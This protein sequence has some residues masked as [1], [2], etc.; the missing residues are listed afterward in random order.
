MVTSKPNHRWY[1]LTPDRFFV[2]LLVVQV[3]LFLSDRF[4]WFTFNEHKGWTVLIAVGVVCCA[5]L[6]M[7]MWGI[8]CLCLRWRF[9]FSFQSL[10]LFLVVVSVPL[11]WFAW[12]M[13]KARQQREGSVKSS[14][15]DMTEEDR[16]TIT[17]TITADEGRNP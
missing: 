17:A 13:Q 14:M 8:I 15:K 5:V 1:H 9:Q 12:E 3:F 10:L 2:G 4:K 6:V 7:L 11:G 16:L